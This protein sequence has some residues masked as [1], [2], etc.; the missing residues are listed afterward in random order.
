MKL[1]IIIKSSLLKTTLILVLYAVF[2]PVYLCAQTESETYLGSD[3][4]THRFR[5]SVSPRQLAEKVVIPAFDANQSGVSSTAI[6]QINALVLDKLNRTPA[7]RK[8]S[9]QLIYTARMLQNQPAA[10]GVPYL[11]T[12]VELD[13]KNRLFVDIVAAFLIV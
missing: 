3:L 11:E 6:Q 8:I 12:G 5:P 9:S 10:E 1:H 7:Q 2:P 4:I 13:S